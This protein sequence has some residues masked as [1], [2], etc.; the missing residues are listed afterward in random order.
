M[1]LALPDAVER[2]AAREIDAV[3][4]E[5]SARVGQSIGPYRLVRMLGEGG[6]GVVYLATQEE[7]IRRQ[8][9]LKLIK[10]GM[11]SREVLERFEIERRALELMDHPGIARVLDAGATAEGQPYFVMEYVPGLP[12]TAYCDE[13]RLG[14]GARIE[15][16]IAVCE[17]VQHAHL[18]GIIHRD[19]K[20]S[21]VLV[22]EQDGRPVP[23]VIDFGLAKATQQRL[24][25]RTAFTELGQLIGTPEYM[26]PEQARMA[27]DDVDTR[28]DLYSLGVMLFELLVGTPPLDPEEL[29]KEGLE[30][31][32][33]RIQEDM[34]PRPSARVSSLGEAGT[35]IALE[36]GTDRA[37]L[38]RRLQGDLD[39]VV[40]KAIE[41]EPER[42]YATVHELAADLERHLNHEPV[43]AGPP[44]AAYRVRKFVRRHRVGVAAA[45]ALAVV[46]L[47]GVAGTTAG[48]I[49]ASRAQTR[50]L[51]AEAEAREETLVAEEVTY[52]LIE[53]FQQ[54]NP[55]EAREQ[56]IT[57]REALDLGAAR[58]R[59]EFPDRP[60]LRARIMHE[61]GSVYINLGLNDEAAPLLEDAFEIR[62]AELPADHP[63][64][65]DSMESLGF[66]K[67]D[68]G[69]YNDALA[70]FQGSVE[71][72]EQAYGPN[73]PMVAKALRN[74][75][76][77][78]RRLGQLDEAAENLGRA[79]RIREL[80]DEETESLAYAVDGYA[81][82]L[83][84][85]GR[86]DEAEPM[87]LRALELRRRIHGPRHYQVALSL[88]NTAV[89]YSAQHRY[90]EAIQSLEESISISE[91]VLG[92][93][94]PEVADSR[95]ALASMLRDVGRADEAEPV[96][97]R[98][99]EILE[100]RK[101]PD[102]VATSLARANLGR[103][104]FDLGDYDLSESH[105]RRAIEGVERA[106]GPDHSRVSYPMAHL[107]ELLSRVGRHD[108]SLALA[109]RVVE[110]RRATMGEEHPDYALA[111][112]N[113]GVREA[114][115]VEAR[116]YRSDQP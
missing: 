22:T 18:K 30:G 37:S 113:L 32:L 52:F 106:L 9:A 49:R 55:G 61:I 14:F 66:L 91:E 87:F 92:P 89:L 56:P 112:M 12:I 78:Y 105:Y 90:D 1:K 24:A 74:V 70:L 64:L 103:I 98:A 11:D 27:G 85:Q 110:I 65:A 47:L 25:E 23:K 68:L 26:S 6:M 116:R 107:S 102:H 67:H 83:L 40:M 58:V 38:A 53:L 114:E 104:Y 10:L 79:V 80:E 2:E 86:Y 77:A 97:Q 54:S 42:R 43:L 16:F 35:R 36:R 46:L 108:E 88:H 8:V 21:N 41:K 84:Y 101:G 99:L 63:Y 95:S 96:A 109:T 3:S 75:G 62:K 100:A 76:N 51:S 44:S 115:A 17:A 4:R 31:L 5:S 57:A 72:R 33:R 50:A 82:V 111:V 28:T 45:T 93:D 59:T 81:A 71:I 73:D 34:T 7:P 15:L 69:E 29:R 13:N 19:L 20:P 60:L 39:W 48:W 94:H